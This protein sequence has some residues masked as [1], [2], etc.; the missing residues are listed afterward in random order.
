MYY[1]AM[2]S[3][4]SSHSFSSK[5]SVSFHEVKLVLVKV[6]VLSATVTSHRLIG[7]EARTSI[8]L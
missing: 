5:N 4:S 2:F 8:T 7:A 6:K 3:K 1:L